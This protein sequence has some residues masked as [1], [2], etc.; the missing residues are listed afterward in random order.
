M[1][2]TAQVTVRLVVAVCESVP[3]RPRIVR[4]EVPGR[5]RFVLLTFSVADQPDP[6]VADDGENE[7]LTRLGSPLTLSET[8][9]AKPL[10]GVIVTV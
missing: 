3:L 5:V 7:A 4:V 10:S 1:P 9:P 2:V 6:A 8:E